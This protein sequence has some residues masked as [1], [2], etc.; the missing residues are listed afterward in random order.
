MVDGRTP[1]LQLQL[2]LLNIIEGPWYTLIR[3][4][5]KIEIVSGI[6]AA[7]IEMH[8]VGIPLEHIKFVNILKTVCYISVQ[9]LITSASMETGL[10]L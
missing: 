10:N 4:C 8:C 3:F 9:M 1:L 7:E 5:L 2:Q 6:V